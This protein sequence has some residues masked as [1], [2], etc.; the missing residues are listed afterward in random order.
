MKKFEHKFFG[1]IFLA[2]LLMGI[3]GVLSALLESHFLIEL[4]LI[5]MAWI[6]YEKLIEWEVNEWLKKNA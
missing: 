2:G 3:V 5:I 1:K 6:I 4:V